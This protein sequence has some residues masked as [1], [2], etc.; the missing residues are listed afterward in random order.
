V[1]TKTWHDRHPAPTTR[2]ALRR[3]GSIAA[4][5]VGG[6][7]VLLSACGGGPSAGALQGKSATE[8]VGLSISAFHRQHSFH[9]V[10]KTVYGKQTQVQIGDV[11]KSSAAES[12]QSGKHPILDAV[13]VDGAAYLRA[14]TKLLENTLALSTSVATAHSGTWLALGKGDAAYSEVADSLSATSAIEVFV[15]E[16]PNL[17]IA[18][19]VTFSGQNALAVEGTS[20]AAPSNGG[21]AEVTL[22][23]STSSPFFPLGATLVVTNPSGKVVERD[24]A[25]FGRWNERVAP[26]VPRGATPLASII[27][28]S[29]GQ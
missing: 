19:V 20:L 10:S 4:I 17:H 22:F 7:G 5:V 2:R 29:G 14:G 25:L 13:L 3:R 9:F 15:P 21:V 11:S 6:L 27:G 23:V 24:A 16:E 8:V 12:L 26:R 1:T 18:G 28:S